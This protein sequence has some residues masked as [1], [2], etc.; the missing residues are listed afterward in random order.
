[1]AQV[2]PRIIDA[3]TGEELWRATDCASHCGITPATWRFYVTKH[4]PQP[5]AYLDKRTPLWNAAE[6][7]QWHAN[8]PGRG[9]PAN[10]TNT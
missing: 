8:R 3:T 1:M 6:V 5:T 4:A 10:H 2:V 7:Q 9:N